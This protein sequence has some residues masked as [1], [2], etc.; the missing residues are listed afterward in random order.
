MLKINV[1]IPVFNAQRFIGDAIQSVMDQTFKDLEIIV[2]DDGSTDGTEK[3]VRQFS[4]P[5]SYCRQQNKGAGVARNLG[6]S[7]SQGDWIAF[8]DADDVWYPYKLAVQV[9]HIETHAGVSFFYS[10]MDMIDEN[11]QVRERGLLSSE[12]KRRKEKKPWDIASI[13][14]NNLP[15]PYPS[16]TLFRKDVFSKAGGFNPI[17]GGSNF[18]DFDLFARIARI[19]PLFFVPQSL[20]KYRIHTAQGTT[21][22]LT[23]QRNYLIL[24]SSLLELW[25]DDPKKKS[26]VASNL[27][28]YY[29]RE[30]KNLVRAGNYHKA[31]QCFQKSSFYRPLYWKNLRRWALSYL[32]AVRELYVA[33]KRKKPDPI[34]KDIL[35]GQQ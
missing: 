18:E 7:L 6:V 13:A 34:H 15:F 22:R 8:L 32:P 2:V 27:A 24:L 17:F 11:G 5:I 1:V 3:I 4:G 23:W 31:R 30:G 10:D 21:D 25:G 19:T 14:F 33:W 28:K 20:V 35:P 26:V 29:T 16:T 9:E 12:L